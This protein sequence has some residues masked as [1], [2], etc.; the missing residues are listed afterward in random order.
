MSTKEKD[1]YNFIHINKTINLF[2]KCSLW[3]TWE[4]STTAFIWLFLKWW[5]MGTIITLLSANIF[6]IVKKNE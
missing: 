3:G 4:I 2:S 1:K 5:V 6:E